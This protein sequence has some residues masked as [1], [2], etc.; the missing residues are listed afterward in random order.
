MRHIL[1]LTDYSGDAEN[2]VESAFIFAKKYNSDL[3]IYHNIEEE[4]IMTFD[5]GNN[6]SLDLNSPDIP[7][8]KWTQLAKDN[9]VKTTL[10]LSRKS[11]VK[12]I[13]EIIEDHEID[14]VIMG[15]NGTSNTEEMI[16][17]SN[18]EKVINQIDTPVL[19]INDKI[20]DYRIDNIVFA[21]DYDETDKEVIKY[22]LDFIKPTK[23]AV[24]HLL[25]VKTTSLFS[26]PTVLMNSFVKE[27][28][29]GLEPYTVQTHSYSDYSVEAGIRHFMEEVKP[30]LLIMNNKHYNPLIRFIKGSNTLKA[31]NNSSFPVLT[32]DYK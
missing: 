7:I 24:I 31:V 19:V 28:K 32:I 30:D 26:L 5:L 23:D 6:G 3:T 20:T 2:A 13:S 8:D 17:G 14:L 15:S 22:A 9:G 18:T 4:E 25:H 10:L 21:S 16:W 12:S 11:F 29:K 1:T 27:F